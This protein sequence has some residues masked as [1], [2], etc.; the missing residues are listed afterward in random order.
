MNVAQQ[1]SASRTIHARASEIF[2]L[3]A[4]PTRQVVIDGSGMLR[5]PDPGT[6]PVTGAGQHF[7]MRMHN[8]QLGDYYMIN[9]VT[10][11]EPDTRIGWAPDLDPSSAEILR[12]L[13]VA[14]ASGHTFTYELRKTDHLE[15]VVTQTYDWSGVN[16]PDFAKLCPFLSQE[17]LADSLSKLAQAVESSTGK[18]P[19]R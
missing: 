7:R 17:Q 12:K 1:R 10:S 8:P 18:L 2:A 6:T 9:T 11:F 4:D 13:G 16:D 15:T 3:L 5:G 19:V 14:K